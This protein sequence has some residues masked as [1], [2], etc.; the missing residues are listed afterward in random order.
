MLK[1]TQDRVPVLFTLAVSSSAVQLGLT[2][3]LI[4][5]SSHTGTNQWRGDSYRTLLVLFLFDALWTILLMGHLLENIFGSIFWIFAAAIVWGSAMGFVHNTKT[6]KSCRGIPSDIYCSHYLSPES[7]AWV[8]FMLC[9][10]TLIIALMWVRASR[11][12]YVTRRGLYV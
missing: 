5:A 7:L 6:R 3:Y 4:V 2:A 1:F 8:E 12:G 11:K 10:V 9:V